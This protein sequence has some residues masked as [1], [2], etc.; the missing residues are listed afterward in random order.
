MQ[1]SGRGR[2]TSGGAVSCANSVMSCVTHQSRRVFV[3]INMPRQVGYAER[4]LMMLLEKSKN[5]K[6]GITFIL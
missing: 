1:P 4:K 2:Q 3:E 5:I 6:G